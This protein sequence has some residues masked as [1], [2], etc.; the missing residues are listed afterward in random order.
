M[1]AVPAPIG[2]EVAGLP[3]PH[4]LLG[5]FHV[6]KFT[7]GCLHRWP[8]DFHTHVSQ[9]VSPLAPTILRPNIGLCSKLAVGSEGS[10]VQ[11][12]EGAYYQVFSDASLLWP[13]ICSA[14][15]LIGLIALNLKSL[16]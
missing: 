1:F 11:R 13:L 7:A 6:S 4:A 16:L 2:A 14:T 8:F 3:L 9:R 15:F 5:G 12:N 10:G